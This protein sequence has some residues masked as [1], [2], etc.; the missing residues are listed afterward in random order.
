MSGIG[1]DP[2]TKYRVMGIRNGK[3]YVVCQPLTAR[4]AVR[5]AEGYASRG[6]YIEQITHPV[7]VPHYP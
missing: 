1:T 3:P 5:F 7:R 2:A 4:E 6:W